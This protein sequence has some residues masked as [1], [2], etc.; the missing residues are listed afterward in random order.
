MIC[1][2]ASTAAAT[3]YSL[4]ALEIYRKCSTTERG[5]SSKVTFLQSTKKQ[6]LHATRCI[7]SGDSGSSVTAFR[8]ADELS[9]SCSSSERGAA[10]Q[11]VQKPVTR[12]Q[13]ALGA[14]GMLASA[15]RGHFLSASR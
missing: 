6:A 13:L 8:E 15:G 11:Q 1:N 9:K 2:I 4:H 5:D 12:R 3:G 10:H 7:V 14:T